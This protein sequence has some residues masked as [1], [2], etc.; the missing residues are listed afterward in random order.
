MDNFSKL[1]ITPLN[2][3][4]DRL[5]HPNLNLNLN[6]NTNNNPNSE[7]DRLSEK[8]KRIFS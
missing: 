8:R 7:G 2:I 1:W 4:Y 5:S 3:D 6:L